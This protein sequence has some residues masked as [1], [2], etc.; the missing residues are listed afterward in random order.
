MRDLVNIG[1]V[2]GRNRRRRENLREAKRQARRRDEDD[3]A[4]MAESRREFGLTLTMP[5]GESPVDRR[6]TQGSGSSG[7][8]CEGTGLDRE[9]CPEANAV[10]MEPIGKGVVE[11]DQSP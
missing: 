3:E 1:G 11:G 8:V 5:D 2:I 4:A 9:D 10:G 7:K 6:L